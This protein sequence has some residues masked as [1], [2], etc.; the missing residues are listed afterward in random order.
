MEVWADKQFTSVG[1]LAPNTLGP[2]ETPWETDFMGLKLAWELDVK[3]KIY[4]PTAYSFIDRIFHGHELPCSSG[5][6]LP[7]RL[8]IAFR[9]LLWGGTQETIRLYVGI[10]CRWLSG[11]K[12]DWECGPLTPSA[13]PLTQ[14]ITRRN[15]F[16]HHALILHSSYSELRNANSKIS[17]RFCY[18]YILW[19]KPVGFKLVIEFIKNSSFPITKF[20]LK[21]WPIRRCLWI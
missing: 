14:G 1:N 3:L 18:M 5:L 17:K 19:Q 7:S 8:T 21:L 4:P 15:I 11:G 10:V 20:P 16:F 12:A 2:R 13:M 6:M 9:A